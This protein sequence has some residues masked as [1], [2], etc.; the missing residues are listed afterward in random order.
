M[1]F[2]DSDVRLHTI[3]F[4][5]FE[6]GRFCCLEFHRLLGCTAAAVLP[7]PSSGKFDVKYHKTFPKVYRTRL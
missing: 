4:W 5:L 7:K 6:V 2:H 1:I 3:A